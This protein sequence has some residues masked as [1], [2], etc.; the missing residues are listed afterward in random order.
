MEITFQWLWPQSAAHASMGPRLLSRGNRSSGRSWVQ[1]SYSFNGA[2][3][4]EPWKCYVSAYD[5]PGTKRF[6]GA[7][8]VEPW[9][10]LPSVR[11]AARRRVAS[12]GPRLL[13]RGN[14]PLAGISLARGGRFNGATAVEPW[15]YGFRSPNGHG[16][17]YAS[18]GPRLLSRG[19]GRCVSGRCESGR[20]SMGP[21]LLSRG[22][23]PGSS[24]S[25]IGW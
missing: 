4:V 21:R 19:N 10:S 18:M 17:K 3:A 7:T 16:S 9:K 24:M 5:P 12:M 15:K 22:N 23:V 11:A 14:N 1:A 8:A 13:S 20:A 2:T 25:T 6:N